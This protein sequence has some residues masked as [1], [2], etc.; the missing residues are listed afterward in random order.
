MVKFLPWLFILIINMS[1]LES[2]CSGINIFF[3]GNSF[4]YSNYKRNYVI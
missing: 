1:Y 4:R 2:C 3:H